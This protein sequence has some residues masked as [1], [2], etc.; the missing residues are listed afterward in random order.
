MEEIYKCKKQLFCKILQKENKKGNQVI[1]IKEIKVA[2][3]FEIL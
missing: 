2:T 3:Q 1:I